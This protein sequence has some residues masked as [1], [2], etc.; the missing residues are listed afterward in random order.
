MRLQGSK[1][2]IVGGP[3]HQAKTFRPD[4]TVSEEPWQLLNSGRG[5]I[6][7]GVRKNQSEALTLRHTLCRRLLQGS[8]LQCQSPSVF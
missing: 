1:G 7:S 4:F 6:K 8:S 5:M 2:P 3:G